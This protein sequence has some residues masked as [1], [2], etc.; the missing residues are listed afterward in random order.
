MENGKK[1]R[2]LGLGNMRQM[3]LAYGKTEVPYS[4]RTKRAMG[5]SND[6]EVY[7][8]K[9][10]ILGKVYNGAGTLFWRGTWLGNAPLMEVARSTISLSKSYKRINEYWDSNSGG[11]W[12]VLNELIQSHTL[13]KLE[14]TILM[15]DN[16]DK[17]S[18]EVTLEMEFLL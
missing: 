2:G 1:E 6:Y 3:N 8:R 4:Q 17:V 13:S 9:H 5:S 11:Q 12:E 14:S 15:E 18:V 16:E 7:K 10:P